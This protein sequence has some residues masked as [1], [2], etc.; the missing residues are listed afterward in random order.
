MLILRTLTLRVVDVPDTDDAALGRM[1]HRAL[2]VVVHT[3]KGGCKIA[4]RPWVLGSLTEALRKC[5]EIAEASEQA[6]RA[7]EGTAT[8]RFYAERA[9]FYR[10]FLAPTLAAYA[11]RLWP[12]DFY[13]YDHHNERYRA[14][15]PPGA[16]IA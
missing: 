9:V 16:S 5:T 1:Y 4:G 10:R 8:G 2:C 15:L 12:A 7:F 14:M 13:D 6:A 3:C 11:P